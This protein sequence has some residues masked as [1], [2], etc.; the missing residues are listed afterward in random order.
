M[1]KI[2]IL[3]AN[4]KRARAR[5]RQMSARHTAAL[6]YVCV[7]AECARVVFCLYC[8]LAAPN[9]ATLSMAKMRSIRSVAIVYDAPP[10]VNIF[11]RMYA[12]QHFSH[13]FVVVTVFTV[14]HWPSQLS[15]VS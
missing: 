12:E 14:F 2:K 1:S 4:G 9:G 5:V 10:C 15:G 13:S 6:A 7:W 8:W 3:K 11:A